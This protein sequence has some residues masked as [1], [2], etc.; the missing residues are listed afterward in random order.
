MTS[1]NQAYPA[2]DGWSKK[3]S[4]AFGARSSGASPRPRIREFDPNTLKDP[5]VWI[6]G[7]LIRTKPLKTAEE[8]QIV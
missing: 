3:C 6:A 5:R 7:K 1:S 2:D 8:R 4:R